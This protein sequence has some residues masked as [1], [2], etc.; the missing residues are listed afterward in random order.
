MD[1]EQALNET[2]FVRCNFKADGEDKCDS[3]AKQIK[4]GKSVF[5]NRTGYEYDE[6]DYYCEACTIRWAKNNATEEYDCPTCGEKETK[7]VGH[8]DS[9]CFDCYAN[10][11]GMPT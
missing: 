10:R 3:C 4:K 6:G 8:P 7:F 11:S 5:Y 2:N 9:E 1:I